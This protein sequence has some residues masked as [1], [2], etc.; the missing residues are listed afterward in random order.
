MLYNT[1]GSNNT[2]IGHVA[3][4]D[5]TTASNNTAIG[6]SFVKRKHYR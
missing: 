2:A 5:N 6:I 4:A 1:T 3:L